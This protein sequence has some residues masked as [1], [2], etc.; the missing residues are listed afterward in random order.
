MTVA[1]DQSSAR[2]SFGAA[3]AGGRRLH[4]LPVRIMH[5]INAVAIIIMIGSGWEIYNDEIVFGWLTFPKT[6]VI[7][8]WAATALQWHFFGMW[9]LGL[10]GLCYLAYGLFTGRFRRKLLPI[11]P[12]ELVADIKGALS[13]HLAHDDITIYNAVQKVLYVG[14]ILIVILQVT[15]GLAVWKPVQFPT[16]YKLFVDFQ[17][18]RLVHFIGMALI[19]GFVVIHVSLALLVPKTL[20]AMVTGGPRAP[21]GD[22]GDGA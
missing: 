14:V 2:P 22:A 8:T 15:S 20:V 9:I 18:A 13:F 10:N 21:S 1:A 5:W 6:I 3:S 11:R 19:C 17:G 16:L 7:G 4:P 12:R